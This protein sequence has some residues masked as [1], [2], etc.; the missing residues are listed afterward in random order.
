MQ[1]CQ[2]DH[3]WGTCN[4]QKVA[5]WMATGDQDS[6]LS[7]SVAGRDRFVAIDQC[8]SS[9]AAVDPSPCVAYAGCASG[10]PV[11][12]CPF[13]GVH[14]VQSWEPPALMRFFDGLP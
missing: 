2:P 4:G 1:T 7:Q 13:V 14:E 9:T 5:V 10:N 6:L 11:V 12:W 3:T 8:G